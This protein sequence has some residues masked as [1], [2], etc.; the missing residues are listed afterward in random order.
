[1]VNVLG[2]G[3]VNMMGVLVLELCIHTEFMGNHDAQFAKSSMFLL[4][5]PELFRPIQSG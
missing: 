2:N 5:L 3:D 1:M 4:I